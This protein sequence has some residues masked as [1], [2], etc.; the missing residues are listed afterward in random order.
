MNALRGKNLAGASQSAVANVN[1]GRSLEKSL[2]KLG[3]TG[4]TAE[5]PT[6][7]GPVPVRGLLPEAQIRLGSRMEPIGDLSS[8][9]PALVREMIR[10]SMESAQQ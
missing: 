3:Q 8:P 2:S 10:K 1:I 9:P 7:T 4:L 5:R 6:G